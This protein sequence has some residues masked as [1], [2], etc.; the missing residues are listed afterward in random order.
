M[1]NIRATLIICGAIYIAEGFILLISPERVNDLYGFGTLTASMS[2]LMAII[3]STFIAAGVWFL[4][5]VLDPLRN[6][7]TIKFA[8]L[9]SSLLVVGPLYALWQG[10]VD[11][12]QVWFE[13]V[14]NAVFAIALLVFYPKKQKIA[15][16]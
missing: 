2:Y 10:Y 13:M 12:N 9:W 15:Q 11:I 14:L 6:I 3:G 8:I 16:K 4:M 5:T 1:R 7:N